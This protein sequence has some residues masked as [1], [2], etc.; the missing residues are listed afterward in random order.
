MNDSAQRDVVRDDA[1]DFS[2][3]QCLTCGAQL[4]DRDHLDWCRERVR[5]RDQ[6]VGIK[7]LDDVC[8]TVTSFV[9]W[10]SDAAA[11]A[12]T[13]WIAATHAQQ[14]WEHATRFVLES[15][16]KRCG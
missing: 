13:L 9:V 10:P 16:I 6:D 11:V 7:V 1:C 15:P 3:T 8:A 2:D 4:L 5:R 14:S 12:Y